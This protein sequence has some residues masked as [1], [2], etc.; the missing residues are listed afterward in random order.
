[1]PYF[2]AITRRCARF[3]E[4]SFAAA[5]Y[6]SAFILA[7]FSPCVLFFFSADGRYSSPLFSFIVR[8]RLFLSPSFA[9][10]MLFSLFLAI[11]AAIA[12][13]LSCCRY[14]TYAI[15]SLLMLSQITPLRRLHAADDVFR[16]ADATLML[17]LP[18]FRCYDVTL[19]SPLT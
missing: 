1:M 8:R 11:F 7:F 4:A 19:I 13:F 14:A 18:L 2:F 5:D 12:S 6:V 3:F 15:F 17:L 10:R 16:Y 9:F